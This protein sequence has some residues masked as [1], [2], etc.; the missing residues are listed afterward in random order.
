MPNCSLAVNPSPV[1]VQPIRGPIRLLCNNETERLWSDVASSSEH[2]REVTEF[3]ANLRCSG[4]ED[5]PRICVQT[6]SAVVKRGKADHHV[7]LI[8]DRLRCSQV[9]DELSME[10]RDR[11]GAQR[12]CRWQR[13]PC[14]AGHGRM[15]RTDRVRRVP[16]TIGCVTQMAGATIALSTRRPS[17]HSPPPPARP[18]PSYPPPVC[19]TPETGSRP[20]ERVADTGAVVAVRPQRA[21]QAPAPPRLPLRVRWAASSVLE[22]RSRGL[23]TSPPRCQ[24]DRANMQE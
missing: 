1:R 9:L 13:R 11:A 23:S 8:H 2:T 12:S 17:P 10:Q 7:P 6:P 14:M 5:N 18:V 24:G 16:S 21:D 15:V 3:P 4:I 19:P 20:A 22:L